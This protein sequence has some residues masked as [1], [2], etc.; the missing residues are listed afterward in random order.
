MA[1][2]RKMPAIA[3]DNGYLPAGTP[4]TEVLEEW[5]RK[6]IGVTP[7]GCTVA[8]DG[9]CEHQAESWFVILGLV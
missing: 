8:M 3:T 4:D 2:P 1:R 5:W 9:E 7:C 6:G